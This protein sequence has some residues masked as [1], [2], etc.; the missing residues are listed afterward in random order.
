M[1][2]RASALDTR[3]LLKP[4]SCHAIASASELGTPCSAAIDPICDALRRSAVG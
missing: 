4:L 2:P 3:S 1:I